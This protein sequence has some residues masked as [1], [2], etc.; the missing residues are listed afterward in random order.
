MGVCSIPI[1]STVCGGVGGV[2]ASAA[3]DAVT[4]VASYTQQAEV[5]I[6]G[7][8]MTLWAPIPT[9][10]PSATTGAV[11]FL[12]ADT[13]WLVGFLAVLGLLLAAGKLAWERRGEPARMAVTGLINLVVVSGAS[14]TFITLGSQAG[15][16][17]SEWILGQALGNDTFSS[18]ASSLV[19]LQTTDLTAMLMIILGIFG[20]ISC[21]IQIV[22][23]IVRVAM[24]GL[25]AGVLPLGAAISGTQEGKAWFRKMCAW[26]L[27]FMLY[28]PVAATVYA[29]AFVAMKDDA[30]SIDQISGLVMLILA[31][32]ALPALMRFVT[33][34]VSGTTGG[35]GAGAAVAGG[36]VATGARALASRSGAGG[37]GGGGQGDGGNDSGGEDSA[38]TGANNAST[39]G[40]GPTGGDASGGQGGGEE[41]SGAEG[42]GGPTGG[43]ATGGPAGAG[44][45]GQDPT[46]GGAAGAGS[47]GAAAGGA[48]GG[49]AAGAASAAPPVAA[50]MAAKQVVDKVKDTAKESAEQSAG[51]DGPSGS[52]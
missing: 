17:Y 11:G 31:T 29:Y 38:P 24:L 3:G 15:D 51:E 21:I 45:G 30:N 14:I 25:L 28:K 12:R 34:M 9:P 44:S 47:E 49:A 6:L 48:S 42:G 13:N 37:G 5:D 50:V 41:P 4:A 22:L 35:G 10:T 8:M 26:L 2:V 39:S 20:I 43:E 18:S 1:V 7:T 33:P 52:Q 40:G 16:A 19:S 27:A 23:M 32:V 36:A 46:G